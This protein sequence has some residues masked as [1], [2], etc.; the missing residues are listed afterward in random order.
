MVRA[1]VPPPHVPP[2]HGSI[3]AEAVMNKIGAGKFRGYSAGSQ[4][5]GQVHPETLKLLTSLG[6]DTAG[7]RSKSLTEFLKEPQFDFVLTVCDDVASEASPIWSHAGY[8]DEPHYRVR[9]MLIRENTP[10]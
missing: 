3:I 9:E 4:P 7:L 1:N 6:Y 2:R 5:K 8:Y 10:V